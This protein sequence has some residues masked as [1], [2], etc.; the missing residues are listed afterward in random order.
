[1]AWQIYKMELRSGIEQQ[2]SDGTSNDTH[3]QYSPDGQLILY[4]SAQ[5]GNNS[6]MLVNS[7]G[8][9]RR[10]IAASIGS[11]TPPLWSHD[12]SLIALPSNTQTD[13][14]IYVYELS[15]GKIRKLTANNNTNL[16]FAWKCHEPVLV[17]QSDATQSDVA[18]YQATAL[19][20]SDG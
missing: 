16:P 6:V 11:A 1:G 10:T 19:P 15:S 5:S 20:T 8:G 13:K 7:D 18:F 17:F 9:D 14:N 12:G 3:P 2:I 4:L